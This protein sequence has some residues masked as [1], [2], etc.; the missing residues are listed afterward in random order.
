[1]KDIY[2]QLQFELAVKVIGKNHFYFYNSDIFFDRGDKMNTVVKDWVIVTVIDDERLIGVILY[3]II[4]DG[5]SRRFLKNDY[6]FISKITYINI[7]NQ[8]IK[9]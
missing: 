7:Y 5:A 3:A 9:T 6:I 8:L 2:A 1:M 4:V